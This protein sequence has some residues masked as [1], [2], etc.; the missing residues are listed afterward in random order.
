MEA[1]LYD[2]DCCQNKN[3]KKQKKKQK[4]KSKKKKKPTMV[5]DCSTYFS[6]DIK[7]YCIYLI[8]K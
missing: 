7:F 5:F 6:N 4:K 1:L 8:M 2:S 3:K